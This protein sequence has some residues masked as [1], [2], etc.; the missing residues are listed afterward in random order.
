MRVK[1]T[2]RGLPCPCLIMRKKGKYLLKMLNLFDAQ[3]LVR[4]VSHYKLLKIY[5]LSSMI[6]IAYARTETRTAM[7]ASSTSSSLTSSV[8]MTTC[9][10]DISD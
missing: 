4:T 8:Q 10:N 6:G 1:V 2:E 5:F 9:A 7:M 3:P